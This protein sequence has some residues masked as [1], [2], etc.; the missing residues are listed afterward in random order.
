MRRENEPPLS[1]ALRFCAKLSAQ[2]S[3]RDLTLIYAKNARDII[4]MM[5]DRN[6]PELLSMLSIIDRAKIALDVRL[7]PRRKENCGGVTFRP[8]Q[9]RLDRC[10]ALA[11]CN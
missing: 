10:R 9:R 8:L 6:V 4:V 7:M 1:R 3:H 2:I 11:G 5:N